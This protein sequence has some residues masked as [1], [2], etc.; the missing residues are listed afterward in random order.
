MQGG[1]PSL[2][3]Q[4]YCLGH[5]STSRSGICVFLAQVRRGSVPSVCS[6]RLYSHRAR[7]S[8]CQPM[9]V[10]PRP[11]ADGLWMSNAVIGRIFPRMATSACLLVGTGSLQLLPCTRATRTHDPDNCQV[12]LKLGSWFSLSIHPRRY[13]LLRQA[14]IS[15]LV[16]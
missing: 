10:R 6:W 9:P 8:T 7:E 12:G 14:R 11:S 13:T 2:A 3:E 5:Q 15:Y 4:V 16:C 1:S